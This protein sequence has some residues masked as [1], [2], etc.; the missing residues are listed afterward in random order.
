MSHKTDKRNVLYANLMEEVK[1]R[2]D[3]I[4]AG[5]T[6]RLILPTPIVR[7]F[8]W[9]QVRMLCE[10]VALSCL[11]AHGDI[12]ALQSNKLGKAYSADD[13]L[14]RLAKLRPHFYP[15]AITQNLENPGA[16]PG[17]RRYK[18][19]A[20]DPSPLPKEELL[21][22]YARTHRYVHRGTYKGLVSSATPI[23]MNPMF[24]EIVSLTQKISDL[25]GNHVIAITEDHVLLCMLRNAEQGFKVQVATAERSPEWIP[26]EADA[27]PIPKTK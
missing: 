16:T 26:S 2:F 21:K 6:G 5:I 27:N 13:I 12:A 22:L 9:L 11:V 8:C 3:C 7:E 17:T 25:L 24:P 10:L 1:V 20:I 18:S 23:D 4:N 15:I 14:D 19:T